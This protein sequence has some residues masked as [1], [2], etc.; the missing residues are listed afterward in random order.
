[1]QQNNLWQNFNSQENYIE[2]AT[3]NFN[4]KVAY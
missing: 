3:E 2:I 1:M 4:M